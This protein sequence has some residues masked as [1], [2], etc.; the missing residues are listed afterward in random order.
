M[1]E[2]ENLN[3]TK[4][5]NK[6]ACIRNLLDALNHLEKARDCAGVAEDPFLVGAIALTFTASRRNT[7]NIGGL[8]FPFPKANKAGSGAVGWPRNGSTWKGRRG[9]A[10][11]GGSLCVSRAFSKNLVSSPGR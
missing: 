5:P 3:Q 1:P 4:S 10:P 9:N 7:T 2:T 8:R 6:I 11:G